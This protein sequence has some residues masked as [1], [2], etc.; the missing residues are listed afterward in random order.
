[1]REKALIF[2]LAL[3]SASAQQTANTGTLAGIVTDPVG[4]NVAGVK[5]TAVNVNT[6]FTSEG[7]TNETGRYSIPYLNPGR[8]ELR[9]EANGFRTYIRTGIELRAGESPRIDVALELGAVTE[10]VSVS[11]AAPLLTTESA[12]AAGS[13]PNQVFM[14]IPILQLRTYS[15]MGYLPG[16]SSVSGYSFNAVG[17]RDRS[18]ANTLD[19]VS[20]KTPMEGAAAGDSQVLIGAADA[21][22]EVRVLTTGVPAEYGRM[23]GGMMIAVSKSGTNNFHGAA[24]DR[25]TSTSMIHRPYFAT[26]P[27]APVNYQ[28]ISVTAGGPI[29]LPKIYDG[30]N[31]TFI[32]GGWQR[33]DERSSSGSSVA[34]PSQDMLNGDFNFGGIGLPIYDPFTT[35]LVNGTWQRTP[36]PNNRIPVSMFD[37]VA[38]NFLALKPYAT[39][40]NAGFIQ[41]IGPQQNVVGNSFTRSY[42][43]RFTWKVDHQLSPSH[44][45]YGRLTWNRHRRRVKNILYGDDAHDLLDPSWQYNPI[46]F[47][48]PVISDT[49]NIGATM[50]NEFRMAFTR[51]TFNLNPYSFGQGWAQKLGIPNAPADTFPQFNNMGYTANP[52]G[53]S[54]RVAEEITIADSVTK[55]VGKHT[56]K[57]GFEIIRSRYNNLEEDRPSGIYDFTNAT[58]FPFRPNT[59]NP[60][61]GFLLGAVQSAQFTQNRASWLPRWWTHGFFIQ[62][63][64]RPTKNL[65]LNLG[66][67]WSYES[68]YGTKYGQQ[69]QFDPTVRDPLTGLMGAITHP[70]GLL[71]KRDLNNFQPRFGLAWTFRPKFVFRGSFGLMTPDLQSPTRGIAFEEYIASANVQPPAGDPRIAFRLSQGPPALPYTINSDGTVPFLG[72]NYSARN[73]TWFDPNMRMPYVMSWSAGIQWQL[74]ETWLVETLYQGSGGVRLL[75]AWDIN[76]IPLN[77]STDTATLDRIFAATQTYKPYPQFGTVRHY[78]NYGHSTYHGLTLRA[79]KRYGRGITLNTFYTYSKTID[80]SDGDTNASGVTFYNRRLE[81]GVAGYDLTHRFVSTF[82]FDLPFGAGRR[83]MNGGGWK[84][85]IFGDWRL[86]W[87]HILNS[88]QPFTVSYAGSPFRYL[89]GN[90]RPNILMPFDQAKVPDW[91]LGAN[92]FPTSAQNPYLRAD[93]FAYP[94]AYTAGNLGRNTFRSPW[95]FWPQASLAKQWVLKENLRLTMRYDVTNPVTWPNFKVPG[96]TY[97]TSNLGNFGTFTSAG[98]FNAIGSQLVAAIVGRIEW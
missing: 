38:K 34:V 9:V 56:I 23:G 79:E 44:K 17:Q 5:V 47:Y 48:S 16:V 52:G 26:T 96:S 55:V 95:I 36:F 20:A 32:F 6:G 29:V 85:K 33:Q 8:Y 70:T 63:D 75:G 76:Q 25:Y 1:V 19:G 90:A 15:V 35:E 39:P 14:R 78:S 74:A 62:D 86:T 43:S 87:S 49:I 54:Q 11:G 51:Y 50:I 18:L 60:F 41:A 83:F 81:K 84:N 22:Q 37:P 91:S 67:R 59:G 21:M 10:S 71:A 97:N 89:P 80:D 77:V 73:A 65:T 13:L 40:N 57:G 53:H 42:R 3:A 92:R 30:R 68:P 98:G 72:T 45:L 88:G 69:S 93:A 4:S 28:D 31:R 66:L 27:T 94:A 46:D 82:T 7:Q 61:A 24:E 2:A 64:F 58:A 12:T